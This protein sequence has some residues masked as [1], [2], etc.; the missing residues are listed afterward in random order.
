MEKTDT[1][2]GALVYLVTRTIVSVVVCWALFHMLLQPSVRA[3]LAWWHE[4]V[5]GYLIITS[6]LGILD[7]IDKALEKIKEARN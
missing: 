5:L 1:V 4:V 2:L 6:L 3:A 7:A